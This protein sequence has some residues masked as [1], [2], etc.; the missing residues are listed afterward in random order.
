MNCI[1]NAQQIV[2]T[3]IIVTILSIASNITINISIIPINFATLI[4]M[5]ISSLF[6]VRTIINILSVYILLGII[7]IP[8]F[9][10]MKSGINTIISYSG[11]FII[12]YIPFCLIIA[13]FYNKINNYLYKYIILLV[14]NICLYLIGTLYYS[15]L[16]KNSFLI[17]IK[18]C[19]LPFLLIDNIKI[20]FTIILQKKLYNFL[21]KNLLF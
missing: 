16:T 10:N 21:Q 1:S 12:G 18:I 2:K 13:T 6:D 5:I 20:V 7:G 3:A 8:V 4:L 15:F 9:A 17:S 11:G 14:S 19:V